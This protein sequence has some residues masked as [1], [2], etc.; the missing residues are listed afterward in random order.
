MVPAGTSGRSARPCPRTTRGRAHDPAQRRPLLSRPGARRLPGAQPRRRPHAAHQFA[1]DGAQHGRVR[2]RHVGAAARR[3]DAEVPQPLV[4]PVPFARPVPSRRIALA[5]RRSFPRP[6][7]I[8]AIRAAVAACR[9]S[10]CKLRA[11]RG[12]GTRTLAG[13]CDRLV[14]THLS[15][16]K[17]H[18]S[19]SQ[20][21]G[22]PHHRRLHRHRCRRGAR[23]RAAGSN[24]IVHYNASRAAA[25]AV[26]ADIKALGASD[27][28]RRRR[29][30]GSRGEAHRR[31]RPWP[32]SAVSTSWSTTPAA[33]SGAPG[34]RTTP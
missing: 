28:G 8:A 21:Q 33:W 26:A 29:D 31:A 9:G 10:R 14:S 23:V 24:V 18:D 4:V 19:R 15:W 16:S 30:A 5:D 34:S 25:E 27:A 13:G 11:R 12:S 7:A 2:P 3:A 1:G 32:P 6:E 17:F 22:C 20:R